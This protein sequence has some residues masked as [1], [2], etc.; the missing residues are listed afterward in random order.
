MLDSLLP[1]SATIKKPIILNSWWEEYKSYE[2]IYTSIPCRYYKNS[3]ST[4]RDS[5][6]AS[7]TSINKFNIIINP[8]NYEIEIWYE[9]E[10]SDPNVWVI[11]DFIVEEIK[12]Q[13]LFSWIDHIYLEVTKL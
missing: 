3:K 11:W 8:S 6:I 12:A 10:I 7:E 9:V 1:Y 2:A 5:N 4:L 13:R